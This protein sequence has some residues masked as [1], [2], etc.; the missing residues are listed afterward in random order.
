LS[1][2]CGRLASRARG[3]FTSMGGGYGRDPGAGRAGS[4]GNQR[5]RI[6]G[7][8][9]VAPHSAGRRNAVRSR[10][11]PPRSDNAWPWARR[12][13]YVVIHAG[14]T[15]NCPVATTCCR[16][17]PGLTAHSG[18]LPRPGPHSLL[19]WVNGKPG[20]I[21]SIPVGP[22][23]RSKCAPAI[24]RPPT[25][26]HPGFPLCRAAYF[27]LAARPRPAGAARNEMPVRIA[28]C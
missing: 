16:A 1:R 10:R 2:L 6:G 25:P 5:R 11:P 18:P 27:F 12:R 17:R 7:E 24:C 19:Q 3:S 26:D 20:R 15:T 8:C 22:S 14:R 4:A 9:A 28:F 23:V 21:L 13:N